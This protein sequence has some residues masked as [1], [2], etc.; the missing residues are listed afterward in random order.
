MSG[1][2]RMKFKLKVVGFSWYSNS[3]NFNAQFN[4]YIYAQYPL[5]YFY[6]V[7]RRFK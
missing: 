7:E 2:G 6:T 1:K 4:S 3:I 5:G